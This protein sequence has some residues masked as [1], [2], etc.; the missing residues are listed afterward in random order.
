QS[1]AIED[2]FRKKDIDY[3]IY[4][5][6]SFYQRKEIK[7]TL[8]YL[9][10]IINP[11]DEEALKRVINY[12]ARGIG[13]TTVDKL[14][15]AA[16][17]FDKSIFEIV[18]NLQ[19]TDIKINAGTRNKL[20]DFA[21]MI[22]RF[23][24]EAKSKDAF[25][26]A[27]IVVKNTKIVK[28]LE[29]DGTPEGVSRIENI[30]ELMNGIKDFITIQKEKKEDA[31]LAFF[32]ED[33]ALATDFDN[34]SKDD[35]PRVSLMTIHLAKGLEF[36]Y[37]YI[38]GLEETLFPSA[39]SMNTRSELE[40]ERRLFYVA[41]T[42]AEKEAYLSYAETRYR[43]GKL[44]DCEPSRFLEEIDEKY[45][46]YLSPSKRVQQNKFISDDIFGDIPQSTVRFKKPIARANVLKPKQSPKT[47]LPKLSTPKNLKKVSKS[48]I[49]NSPSNLF[50]TN[51]TVGNVVEHNRF[52]KGEVISLE[53]AG[54]NKKAA[55]KFANFG[56]KKLLLQFAK[57]K[58]IG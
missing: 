34:D 51:L 39:M 44:I 50:D 52:G 42:R 7:D 9:R 11:N 12:P 30:Q 19:T 31:S 58:I 32:L 23:Q 2:A 47:V 14:A 18:K 41:L 22:Q 49:S 40:E 48:G 46:E 43:W 15:V 21:T 13:A 3:R 55:I 10:L 20:N 1:R 35:K 27:E 54:P 36:P 25:E 33:V 57:L 26:V 17:H 53:G 4:G 24:I 8:A 38:V 16:N 6:L 37:V 29:A 5:G 45:L 28:D 56:T